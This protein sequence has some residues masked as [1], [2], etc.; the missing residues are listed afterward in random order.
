MKNAWM[1]KF[2][3]TWLTD[4]NLQETAKLVNLPKQSIIVINQSIN[5]SINQCLC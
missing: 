1:R 3:T 2:I 5:Q 4:N